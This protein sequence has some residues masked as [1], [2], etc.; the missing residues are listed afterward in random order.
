MQIPQQD[1]FTSSQSNLNLVFRD[2]PLPPTQ[3]NLYPRV[4]WVPLWSSP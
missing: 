1:L 3:I 4:F 2:W